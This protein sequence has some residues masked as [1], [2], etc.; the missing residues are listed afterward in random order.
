[1]RLLGIDYGIKRIGV[2]LSDERG[3]F[4]FPH[5][6]I[7]NCPT[8]KCARLSLAQ[9]KKICEENEVGKI[10]L[11][12]SVDYHGYPN[13]V[14]KKIEPFKTLLEKETGLAVE[15]EEETLT[16]Y[17]AKEVP[18]I[19]KERYSLSNKKRKGWQGKMKKIDASAAAII[20]RSFI[21]KQKVVE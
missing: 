20:L 12:K 2:A 15:Y 4:A 1:M 6:V 16:T 18:V 21:E 11:G 9:I 3:K 17:E 13:P 10:I 8:Q 14:M 5:S 19:G 7:Q